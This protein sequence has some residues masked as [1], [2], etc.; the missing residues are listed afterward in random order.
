MAIAL[1]RKGYL[2]E[3]LYARDDKTANAVAA[4]LPNG[5]E[6]FLDDDYSRIS[7]DIVLI[8][9][10]DSE[11]ELVAE[12]LANSLSH[13]PVLFHTSGS[14]S[15]EILKKTNKCAAAS[16]HPLVSVSD[17]FVGSKRFADAYFGIEGDSQA[18]EIAESI[19]KNLGGKPISISSDSKALYHASAVMACGHLVALIEAANEMLAMC[20]IKDAKNRNILLPLIKSTIGNLEEQTAAE[21][22]TGTFARLDSET[23]AR[24][25]DIMKEK[26]SDDVLELY[27]QLGLRSLHLVKSDERDNEKLIELRKN[28]SLAK[29]NLKC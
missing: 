10:Q 24:H 9:T 29:R 28:I 3:N 26:V 5:P 8:T 21:A 11:I 12:K 14:L 19:V 6:L 17:A 4:Q 22:L 20:G 7:T 2:V 15:S 27:L 23:F 16:I 13:Q 18:V 1:S 25:V